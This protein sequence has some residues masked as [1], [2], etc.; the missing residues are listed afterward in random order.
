[1]NPFF[2]IPF[3]NITTIEKLSREAKSLTIKVCVTATTMIAIPERL[4]KSFMR[5][6]ATNTQNTATGPIMR[7]SVTKRDRT[8][9]PNISLPPRKNLCKLLKTIQR[10]ATLRNTFSRRQL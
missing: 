2:Q 9:G 1:M 6:L 5:C 8:S 4:G 10:S 3:K 7:I